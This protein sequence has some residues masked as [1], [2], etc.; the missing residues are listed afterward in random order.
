MARVPETKTTNMQL[1]YEPPLTGGPRLQVPLE[2]NSFQDNLSKLYNNLPISIRN[3]SNF[4]IFS[5]L[6]KRYLTNRDN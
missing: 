1:R 5:K 2:N 4:S 3:C 6:V